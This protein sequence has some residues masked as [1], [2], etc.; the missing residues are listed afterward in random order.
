[1]LKMELDMKP[2]STGSGARFYR[3]GW[4]VLL[5]LL[6]LIV[7][8]TNPRVANSAETELQQAVTGY[9]EY[10]SKIRSVS[11]KSVFKDKF[12]AS[13]KYT[14]SLAQDWVVDFPGRR[15][16]RRTQKAPVD[17]NVPGNLSFSEQLMS[18]THLYQ[19]SLRADKGNAWVMTGYRD[20]PQDYW[21]AQTGFIYLS[22]PFGCLQDDSLKFIP[23]LLVNP[24]MT[25]QGDAVVLTG[26]VTGE[27]QLTVELSRSKGW[28]PLRVDFTRQ[29][30]H[31]KH[32]LLKS[33]YLV[34]ESQQIDG[35]WFPVAYR[36]TTEQSAGLQQLPPGIRVKDGVT[37]FQSDKNG[38]PRGIYFD[39]REAMSIVAEVAIQDVK[40][41]QA[42]DD[43]FKLKADVPNGVKVSMQDDRNL[44]YV[45]QDG[46]AVP[47]TA[48]SRRALQERR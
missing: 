28:M 3:R 1:M 30:T 14:N 48:N 32:M 19:A 31:G 29:E 47:K 42:T 44:D 6:I 41:N 45:W 38:N 2:I 18:P 33:T 37:T 25:T 39:K 36:C 5:L 24:S 43:D 4:S 16:W 11:F 40:L 7:C 15:L 23:D 9:A 13:E 46:Q 17:G 10:L 27:Y 12:K 35:I 26:G 22:F 20:V 34:D 21:A 8:A